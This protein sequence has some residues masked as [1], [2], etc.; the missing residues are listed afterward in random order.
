MRNISKR[1]RETFSDAFNNLLDN[2]ET[3][4]NKLNFKISSDSKS[5][6]VRIFT[7]DAHIYLGF[8]TNTLS[9]VMYHKSLKDLNVN[10]FL[11]VL[12]TFLDEEFRSLELDCRKIFIE[13]NMSLEET[14]IELLFAE[15]TKIRVRR[16]F[17]KILN[18]VDKKEI[19]L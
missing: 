9:F 4:L 6:Y 1:I 10:K 11:E 19:I 3:E 18:Y 2:Y 5:G 16:L 15:Q 13:K 14:E 12:L 17:K 7:E 8:E